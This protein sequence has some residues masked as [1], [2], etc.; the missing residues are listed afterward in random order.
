MTSLQCSTSHREHDKQ[1]KKALM[2][3]GMLEGGCSYKRL[4][5]NRDW[6]EVCL[7]AGKSP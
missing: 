2:K 5:K 1:G 7:P 6:A 4:Q 3:D